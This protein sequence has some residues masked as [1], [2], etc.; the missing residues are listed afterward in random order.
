[1]S[2]EMQLSPQGLFALALHEGI[3]PGPYKDSVGVWTYGIG[4]TAAAGPPDPV[5]MKRG[6]PL[7]LDAELIRVV[8]LFARDAQ[9]YTADVRRALR[10]PV[11]QHQFD[12]LVSFH[13]NTGAIARA[14]L[15]K[16]VN[17][18]DIDGAANAF[19]NWTKP[20]EVAKRRSAEKQLFQRGIYPSGDIPVWGVTVTGRVIW[21]K[22]ATLQRA[23]FLAMVEKKTAEA[24]T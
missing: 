8:E 14:T 20:P 5:K 1:M 21:R 6:M 3:V 22:A 16:L 17:A 2:D 11:E 19:M 4:R 23:Q 18:G 15:T 24:R 9:R 10:R 13:Y 7:N 12:A